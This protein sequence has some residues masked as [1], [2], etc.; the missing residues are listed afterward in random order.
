MDAI[1]A[2]IAH[3]MDGRLKYFTRKNP[4]KKNGR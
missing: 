1:T 3:P 4:R 2:K